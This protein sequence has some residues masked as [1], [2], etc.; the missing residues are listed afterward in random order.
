MTSLPARSPDRD[1]DAVIAC[2]RTIILG[3]ACPSRSSLS[4]LMVER[5][6]R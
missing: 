4:R 2:L 3:S 5:D 6:P 1:L